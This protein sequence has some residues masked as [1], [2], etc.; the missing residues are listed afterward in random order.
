[1]PFSGGAI[2]AAILPGSTTRCIRLATNARSS[3]LGSHDAI[4]RVVLVLRDGPAG[5]IGRHAGPVPDRAAE[6]R[7]RQREAECVAGRF[8][9]LVPARQAAHA[10][11]GVR[12]AHDLVHRVAHRDGLGAH[13]AAAVGDVE[14]ERG[15]AHDVVVVLLLVGAALDALREVRGGVR[16]RFG[17]EQIER[18]AR[19][20]SSGSAG[21]SAK[22]IAPARRIA[23]GSSV[24][25][26]RITSSV[27][28]TTREIPVSPTN[29]WC[30][31]SVSMKRHVRA[32]GSKL[33]S[34]NDLS[35]NLPSRSV[36]NVNMKNES[37]SLIGSLNVPQDARVVGVARMALQQLFGL[38]A[39]VAP[40][41]RVQ[42]VHHRPQVTAFLDVHLKQVAQVVQRG[43][44]VSEQPLLLDRRGLGVALGDDQPAQRAAVLAGNLL[45]HRLA[46]IVAEADAPVLLRFR[47]EDSPAVVGHAHVVVVRPALGVDGDRGAQVDVERVEIG[48]PHLLPP[49]QERGLPLLERALQ[50]AVLRELDVVGDA[51]GVVDR[52]DGVTRAPG[53]SWAGYRF[54]RA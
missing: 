5:R 30:A 18:G 31:S 9:Q 35:W 8:D 40:E 47:E 51:F 38:F 3:A 11:L 23:S 44:A 4:R 41:V 2:Q 50:R 48:R 7:A 27:R 16:G 45:P 28:R 39:P 29:M 17:A 43:R 26:S 24:P 6:A 25:S 53:R 54:R 46:E 36:K 20:R 52:H 32:S 37:Q 14:L 10:V 22:S 42:Q 19:T 33:D 12:V 1:M 34:A 49:V 15:V 21:S 13:A